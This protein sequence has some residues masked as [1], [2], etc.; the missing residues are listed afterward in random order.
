MWVV[1]S[2]RA[3]DL[4]TLSRQPGWEPLPPR[5]SVGVWTDDFSD[6]LSAFTWR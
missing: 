4:A 6:I 5:A 2:R 1:M 3:V